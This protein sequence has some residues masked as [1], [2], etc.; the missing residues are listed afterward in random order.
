MADSMTPTVYRQPAEILRSLVRFDTTN[1][2]G[3]ERE[4]VLYIDALLRE[5]GFETTLLARDESRPNLIARL[6]GRGEAPPLLLY[7][8]VDVV[9][10]PRDKWPHPPLEARLDISV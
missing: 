8:H 1:P 2:P 3:N 9:T 4:C 6:P 7:G 10:T 5:A